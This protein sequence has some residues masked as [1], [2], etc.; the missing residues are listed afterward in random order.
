MLKVPGKSN[1]FTPFLQIDC[2]HFAP[3]PAREQ[4]V[5]PGDLA[6]TIDYRDIL[7]EILR[8]RLNNPLTAEVFP[9]HTI[10]E[11]GVVIRGKL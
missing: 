9:D 1:R 3:G 11:R 4:L 2:N 5:G 6:V 10:S 8:K 7:A